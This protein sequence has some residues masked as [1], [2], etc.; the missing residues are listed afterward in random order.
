MQKVRPLDLDL[1]RASRPS[2]AQPLDPAPDRRL[3]AEPLVERRTA[4][5]RIRARLLG[6]S[7]ASLWP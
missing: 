2:A 3:V 4:L 5:R 6:E 1:R 7:V